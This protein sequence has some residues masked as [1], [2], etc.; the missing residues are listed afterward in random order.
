MAL[1]NLTKPRARWATFKLKVANAVSRSLFDKIIDVGVSVKDFG[2]KGDGV[3]DDLQAFK[4]A[5][6]SG[7]VINVP[8]GTYLL[9]NA[10]T[11]PSN[12]RLVGVGTLKV[13]SE[14][15]NTKVLIM[16]NAENV[17]VVGL[18]F[19]GHFSGNNTTSLPEIT[20]QSFIR[21]QYC[22][23]ISFRGCKFTNLFSTCLQFFDT[24]GIVVDNCR[25]SKM[26]TVYTSNFFVS[27]GGSS[28]DYRITNNS[29]E[30]PV[31]FIPVEGHSNGA[32]ALAGTSG[33][34]VV[35]SGL[36]QGNFF[37][38]TG[39][40]GDASYDGHNAPRGDIDIYNDVSGLII[41]G[42]RSVNGQ[43]MF[44]KTNDVNHLVVSNNVFKD[45]FSRFFSLQ[46]RYGTTPIHHITLSGN[47][48]E[49]C[50]GVKL[51]GD[52]T[53]ASGISTIE[54]VVITGNNF[55]LGDKDDSWCIRAERVGKAVTITDNILIGGTLEVTGSAHSDLE[56][57]TTYKSYVI[58]GN[59][60][61]LR[62]V[63]GRRGIQL[64]GQFD[65]PTT[66]DYKGGV[67]AYNTIL[68]VVGADP[69][70]IAKYSAVNL[71]DNTYHNVSNPLSIN[72][73]KTNTGGWS[74]VEKKSPVQG[75]GAM[76]PFKLDTLSSE[77][78]FELD[79]AR[80]AD[81]NGI[82]A[83]K[84][85]YDGGSTYVDSGYSSIIRDLGS[86]GVDNRTNAEDAEYIQIAPHAGTGT[87]E[88][89][90]T[91]SIILSP[92]GHLRSEGVQRASSTTGHHEILSS[93]A[94]AIANDS[95]ITHVA[96]CCYS[97]FG[98]D[99]YFRSGDIKYMAR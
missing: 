44:V 57:P 21:A 25:F 62:N 72:S 12:T 40:Y 23:N 1:T 78:L 10:V 56:F 30:Q 91:G 99:F 15:S 83:V 55:D 13:R 49:N 61:D 94:D 82:I 32:I 27:V 19:D 34:S 5:V 86:D 68:N 37:Q 74:V 65:H 69:I 8:E 11:L 45:A 90:Y 52:R 2:A 64:Y 76:I 35:T 88:A 97:R 26:R 29:F 36:I 92:N 58:T 63:S 38:R 18:S 71:L 54:S 59:R 70:Y 85:S 20:F 14:D 75:D 48:S 24:K 42:N 17:E 43:Y 28:S 47:T 50:Q 73:D 95:D 31:N 39:R 98:G 7:G 53:G 46:G 81:G 67:I 77:H 33:T 79:V 4:D 84:Y 66:G 16:D 9:S 87:G 22:T 3:T 80:A 6:A 89:S 41:E 60:I 93:G 51:D 96:I